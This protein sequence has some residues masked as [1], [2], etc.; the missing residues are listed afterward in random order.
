MFM[1]AKHGNQPKHLP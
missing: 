1:N